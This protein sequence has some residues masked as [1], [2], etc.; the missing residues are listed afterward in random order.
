MGPIAARGRTLLG[1]GVAFVCLASNNT[2]AQEDR[3]DPRLPASVQRLVRAADEA[4]QQVRREGGVA[5]DQAADDRARAARRAARKAVAKYYLARGEYLHM[6]AQVEADRKAA[7]DAIAHLVSVRSAPVPVPDRLAKAEDDANL[8]LA[9]VAD[10]E[11]K[12]D[13]AR[14]GLEEPTDSKAAGPPP[15]PTPVGRGQPNPVG[16]RTTR[17]IPFIPGPEQN[18]F[19][20]DSPGGAMRG[21]YDNS[22]G[23]YVY[24]SS[25]GAF[26]LL[27]STGTAAYSHQGQQKLIALEYL[28]E[29]DNFMYYRPA[30]DDSVSQWAFARTSECTPS[31]CKF[32]VWC[33]DSAGWHWEW[34]DR[35]SPIAAS[36]MSPVNS[37]NPLSS[38]PPTEPTRSRRER[39]QSASASRSDV[40]EELST[41]DLSAG[42]PRR[43]NVDL[44]KFE[45]KLVQPAVLRSV[46]LRR[47]TPFTAGQ[48]NGVHPTW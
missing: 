48:D 46:M 44:A 22:S 19:L 27:G 29:N 26:H 8:A 33:K 6:L 47:V 21:G 37:T 39:L 18:R 24:T 1:A 10:A 13:R 35:T 36:E 14:R 30:S 16:N 20:N 4:D 41:A 12:L 5:I 40:P 15:E 2:F 11:M 43:D 38:P 17:N 28:R 3:N 42:S 31:E 23:R 45:S 32:A 7:D 34:T 25:H 9:A